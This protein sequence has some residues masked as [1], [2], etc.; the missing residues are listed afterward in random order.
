M[1]L[2]TVR[3]LVGPI[4]AVV[5]TVALLLPAIAAAQTGTGRKV[6]AVVAIDSYGDLKQQLTW[7][8]PHVDNP[9]LAAMLESVLLLS[10]QG[11]G[12]NGLDVKRP[13]GVIVTS[14][15]D[16]IG[17]HAAI[18]VK[19]LEKLLGSLQGSTGPIEKDGEVRRLTLPSGQ[20]IEIREQDGWAVIG[21]RGQEFD[22]ADPA[23]LLTPLVTDYTLAIETHP[24][25]MPESLRALIAAGIQQMAAASANQ[26]RPVDAEALQTALA[27]LG[28]VE[29]LTIALALDPAENAVFIENKVI[30][31]NGP[32]A[33]SSTSA[34]TVATAATQDGGLPA[35]AAHAVQPLND[36]QRRQIVAMLDGALPQG[37]DKTMQIVATVVR[38]LVD[39]MADAGG[40][41][42]AVTVD[43]S[44]AGQLPLITAGA[45]IADGP[46]LEKQVK[47]LFGPGSAIPK[48]VKAKFD[49]G[50]VGKANLHTVTID[51]SATPAAGI[52]GPAVE[53][54]L[55]VTPD[56]AFL[57]H[58]G[59]VKARLEKLLETNGKA[60]TTVAAAEVPG[61]TIA[62]ALDRIFT[63]A[64]SMGVGPQAEAAAEQAGSLIETDKDSGSVKASGRPIDGGFVTRLTVGAG[65]IKAAAT[66]AQQQ[67]QGI[68]GPG[69][70]PGQPRQV[71]AEREQA[72]AR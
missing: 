22:I 61:A 64:A 25:V 21:Q 14:A 10:T 7:I 51:V 68:G 31:V 40:L 23:K 28:G 8:G 6:L 54:T 32:K 2:A 44:V 15:N 43:T 5:A 34:L 12:L 59:D 35:M 13:L 39:A 20:D 50:K 60:N 24:S 69:G 19:D 4:A 62:L 37:N 45:H 71:P 72:G 26:G 11:K 46:K 58:G 17:I 29:T 55:A 33:G 66:M 63:Y 38:G 1:V 67:Q 16:D 70:R 49:S 65:A 18:P 47:E 30:A 36:S 42:A 27:G 9:G 3:R 53:L 52:V 48:E 56:Y 57:L 41:D